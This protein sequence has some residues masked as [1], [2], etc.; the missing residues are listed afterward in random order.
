MKKIG[1]TGGIGS[2]KTT[3]CEIFKLLGIAVFHADEQAL[4][5]QNTD[6]EI[7]KF[8]SWRFGKYIYSPDGILDRRRLA[9]IIFND[10]R[11]LA[12]V[13]EVVHPAVRLSFIEWA[14]NHRQEPYVLYEAAIIFES[15]YSAGF[16]MNILVVADEKTRI[17]R[18]V[19][20]DHTTEEQVKQRI[21]NQ[22]PDSQKIKFADYI[23]ENNAG[24]LLIPRVIELDKI[25][26]GDC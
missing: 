24:N 1:I 25:I 12:D 19:R 2:G 23:I 9:K 4:K 6:P 13:N 8:L 22:M 15:G 16:D 10:N 3:V 18:V 11:A 26:R 20:R 14:E 5:I 7:I 17:D 21:I